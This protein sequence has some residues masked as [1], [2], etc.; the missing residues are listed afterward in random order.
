MGDF[1][2]ERFVPNSTGIMEVWK[3]EGM[4]SA[5]RSAASRMEAAANHAGHLHGPHGKL[6]ESGV[7]VLSRTAVGYVSTATEL[8]AVDQK[9]HKTLDSL[10]H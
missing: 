6:Y 9:Y 4:Q 10:N 7:D 5:L 8:G 3:S 2:I 1:H